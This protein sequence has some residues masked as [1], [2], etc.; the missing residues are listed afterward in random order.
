[1]FCQ[2]HLLVRIQPEVNST[3]WF[4]DEASGDEGK[5]FDKNVS[6]Q[7]NVLQHLQQQL[8]SLYVKS[9]RN[10][11][12]HIQ[13]TDALV[14]FLRPLKKLTLVFFRTRNHPF[15]L[16]VSIS[17]LDLHKLRSQTKSCRSNCNS[18]KSSE[19]ETFSTNILSLYLSSHN[20]FIIS[21]P[22]SSPRI[23]KPVEVSIGNP[24]Q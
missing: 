22:L 3:A 5:L 16:E 15:N 8:S 21:S 6:L 19:A 17:A 24:M 1:M 20:S 7:H 11:D 10:L 4:S 18:K 2:T 12:L 14:L 13:K 9:I 23:D